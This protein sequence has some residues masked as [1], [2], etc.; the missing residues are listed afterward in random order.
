MFSLLSSV[1][2]ELMRIRWRTGRGGCVCRGLS[3]LASVFPAKMGPIWGP[4]GLVGR[5]EATVWLP[6]CPLPCPV[7]WAGHS[8]SPEGS[9]VEQR[10]SSLWG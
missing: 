3:Y 5:D 6:G 8:L 10:G 1:I 7:P 9:V 2:R 4:V